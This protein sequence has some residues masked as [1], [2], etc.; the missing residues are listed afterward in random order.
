[1]RQTVTAYNNY[2]K[3]DI[4]VKPLGREYVAL[5][6]AQNPNPGENPV[7][8]NLRPG[9]T[10]E[11]P[12]FYFSTGFRKH[13]VRRNGVIATTTVPNR[14]TGAPLTN[15]QLGMGQAPLDVQL[16]INDGWNHEDIPWVT[17]ENTENR[18]NDVYTVAAFFKPSFRC[19][20][21]SIL[22]QRN[23]AWS[24][25]ETTMYRMMKFSKAPIMNMRY[26]Q[27]Y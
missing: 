20:V 7:P 12:T 8:T 4:T 10:F 25:A 22:N 17:F 15:V 27:Q 26:D 24:V 14:R 11:S 9:L 13:T 23:F 6:S 3:Y 21:Q 1:M 16:G 19:D 5:T 18:S 2:L